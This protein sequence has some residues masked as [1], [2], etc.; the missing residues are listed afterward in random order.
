MCLT[1][2]AQVISREGDKAVVKKIDPV[3]NTISNGVDGRQEIDVSLLSDVKVGDWLIFTTNTAIKKISAEEAQ[4]IN[5][6]LLPHFD[7]KKEKLAKK[8]IQILEK[9]SQKELSV[10]ELEYLLNLE[11]E[12]HLQA[13][14]SEA[15]TIRKMYNRDHICIHGIIEF[16]N[17]CANNCQYCGLRRDN[18][19][20]T[21]YRLTPTE[22][23]ETAV[24]AVKEDS[25]K[26]LVLQSG[27]D[28]WYDDEKLMEIIK[29]IKNQCR[30]FLYLSIGDRSFETY[31]KLK[32]AGAQGVL[33][34]FETSNPKLYNKLHSGKTLADRLDHLRFMKKL[35]YVIATGPIIGLPGQTTKDLANDIILMKESGA[36]M[37]SMG[38]FVPAPGTPLAD[39]PAGGW[40]MS[41]KMIAVTRIY[42]KTARIPITTALETLGPSKVRE[43]AFWGGANSIMFNLTPA[44]YRPHYSIYKDK[45]YDEQKKFAQ[46]GL[47][48]GEASYQMLEDELKLKI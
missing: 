22:I 32:Q 33:Y 40:Q 29:G 15:N 2:P 28:Y 11:D 20:K 18:Q 14:Y 43:M 30:V 23:I 7:V 19:E 4:E 1:I 36:F 34:R 5:N 27:D 17:Y 13:L 41:L 31:Q 47:F 48:K 45:F 21:F 37:P 26:M 35:G 6:L 16:S 38:P 42:L 44:Q 24:K 39:E 25:Y 3:R 9:A 8:F 12:N 10:A 46:W